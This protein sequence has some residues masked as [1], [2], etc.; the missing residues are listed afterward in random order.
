MKKVVGTFFLGLVL[1]GFIPHQYYVSIIEMKHNTSNKKI[2]ISI[3]FIGHDLEYALEKEGFANLNLGTM[4]EKHNADSL[5]HNYISSHFSILINNTVQPLSFFGKE[6][7]ANDDIFCYLESVPT[8][9]ITS[10]EVQS[11]LLTEYFEEHVSI[12]YLTIE[13]QRFNFRLN[14][15]KT[16]EKHSIEG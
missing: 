15:N 4:K 5:L 11:D 12:V 10:I 14:K 1:F 6:V 13:E 2:E 16:K 9:K 8:Q 3:K 7:K